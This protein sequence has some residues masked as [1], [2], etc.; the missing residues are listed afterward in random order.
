MIFD[1]FRQ[2]DSGVRRQYGGTGLGLSISRQLAQLLGG[3]I[4]VASEVGI[5]TTF[6]VTLPL[7]YSPVVWAR[8]NVSRV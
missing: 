1:K 3:E 5:G 6:T 4:T 8:D 2:V 7:I